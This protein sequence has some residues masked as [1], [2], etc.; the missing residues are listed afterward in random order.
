MPCLR[1]KYQRLG[2]APLEPHRLHSTWCAWEVL[3]PACSPL[4]EFSE[5][6][7]CR[8]I[9]VVF[10]CRFAFS[11]TASYIALSV[12]AYGN[13]VPRLPLKSQPLCYH[14][15][16]VS[17]QLTSH[18]QCWIQ[19]PLGCTKVLFTTLVPLSFSTMQQSLDNQGDSGLPHHTR[20]LKGFYVNLYLQTFE[21]RIDSF[22]MICATP[23]GL[24][25]VIVL[26]KHWFLLV[27]L[28]SLPTA[29]SLAPI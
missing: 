26:G 9:L 7:P 6:L 15:V 22:Q 25:F 27:R 12:A 2:N 8:E 1:C 21:P 4:P 11:F 28:I 29:S 5:R 24:F 14:D 16:C 23:S 3:F 10:H 19:W 20:S 18:M 17:A 13:L